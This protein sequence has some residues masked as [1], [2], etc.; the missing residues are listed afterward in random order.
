M[1]FDTV[2]KQ[3]LW[4]GKKK[5]KAALLSILIQKFESRFQDWWKK[6]PIFYISGTLFSDNISNCVLSSWMYS[7]AVRYS[8][9]KIDHVSLL[10]FFKTYLNREPISYSTIMPY[11]CHFWQKVCFVNKYF[12]GLSTERIKFHK[13]RFLINTLR[14][15]YEFQPFPSNKADTLVS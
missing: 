10:V 5:K 12:Q 3:I 6:L 14:I 9:E 4:M 8:T 11:S 7:V 2:T 15:H 13:K 1:Y